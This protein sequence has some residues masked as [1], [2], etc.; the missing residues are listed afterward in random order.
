MSITATAPA[1]T[2]VHPYAEEFPLASED[3]L[4]ELTASIATVGL[5]H[6]LVIIGTVAGVEDGRLAD[7]R[8]RKAACERAR[9][10]APVEVRDF[11]DDDELK[12]FIIGVN[13]TGRRDSMTVQ[14]AAASTALILGEGKRVG[15]PKQWKRDSVPSVSTEFGTNSE[16][17]TWKNS[18][19]RAG[20]ILDQLGREALE[21]VR[22]GGA[23]LNGKYE[24]AVKARDEE[25][26]K[27][28][29]E[30]RMQLEE[31][32]AK[33]FILDNDPDLAQRVETGELPSYASA[34]AAWEHNNRKRAAELRWQEEE[35]RKAEADRR[36]ALNHTYRTIAD[37]LRVIGDYGR[38]EPEAL[39]KLMADYSPQ[40]L[41]LGDHADH[42]KPQNLKRA[43]AFLNHLLNHQENS[44]A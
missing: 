37:A 6:P 28:E 38:Y 8:N 3:E 42:F 17:Q 39:D 33:A 11:E 31:D 19:A 15:N 23:T 27:L 10:S 2:G 4:E 1:I 34:K 25:R 16:R 22:D 30:K 12:E 44:N 9:V 18:L 24:D 41:K 35:K 43:I 40:Y 13:T 20:I 26:N 36:N 21:A 29:W 32:E 5:I 14:I 7:G